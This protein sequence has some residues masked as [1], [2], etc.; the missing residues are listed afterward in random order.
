[1]R[2]RQKLM[3]TAEP[4]NPF[5]LSYSRSSSNGLSSRVSGITSWLVHSGPT[6]EICP[7]LPFS[8]GAGLAR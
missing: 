7:V 2:R 1:M 6:T 5:A 4:V 3:A 8:V